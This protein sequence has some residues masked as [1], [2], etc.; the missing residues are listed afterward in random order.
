MSISQLNQLGFFFII[1]MESDVILQSY[2]ECID[3]AFL[4]RAQEY[5]TCMTVATTY[6]GL[7]CLVILGDDLS[8]VNKEACLMGLKALQLEDGR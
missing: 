2:S 6:I 3:K 4:L 7:A 8:R 1:V 5:P